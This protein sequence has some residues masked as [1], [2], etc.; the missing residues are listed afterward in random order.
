MGEA[1]P[2]AAVCCFYFLHVALFLKELLILKA[3]IIA[4]DRY[5]FL[6][7]ESLLN[8]E[9]QQRVPLPSFTEFLK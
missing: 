1:K 8:F 5:L 2:S 7:V 9:S 3:K 4:F 6:A